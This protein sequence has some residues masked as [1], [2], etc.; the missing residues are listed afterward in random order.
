MAEFTDEERRRLLAEGRALPPEPG[1][2]PIRAG[3]REDVHD[4]AKDVNR[5]PEGERGEVRAHIT[6]WAVHDGTTSA[7]P[8][9][10]TVHAA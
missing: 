5:I 6:R 10:W 7:L 2:F 3:S 9:D 4:A 8:E 1:R